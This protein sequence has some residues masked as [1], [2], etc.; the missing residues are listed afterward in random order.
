MAAILISVRIALEALRGSVLRTTLSTLG[1]VMGAASL[2]AVLSLTDGAE[3]LARQQIEQA[4]VQAIQVRPQ[5]VRTVD[6]LP[7]PTDDYPR[8]TPADGDRLAA[9]LGPDAGV[10][11]VFEGTTTV[12]VTGQRAR[13]AR[14]FGEFER[15]PVA[16]NTRAIARGRA[17]TADEMRTGA[18]VAV[19]GGKLADDFQRDALPGG[20]LGE[21]LSVVDQVVRVVGILQKAPREQAYVVVTPFAVA[22]R[23]V[24]SDQRPAPVLIVRAPDAER[25]LDT[26][27]AIDRFAA[28]QP[29]WA[30]K[31]IVSSFGMDRLAQLG[32]AMQVVRLVFASFTAIS[33]F[34]G[35]IGIMNVLLSS[36]LERTREIGVRKAAGARRR[37]ILLQFLVEASTISVLGAALGGVVGVSGAFAVTAVIRART[38]APLYAAVTVQT[39]AI[40]ALAAIVVG[41]A[42][43]VYPAVRASKL[44][45]IDAIQRE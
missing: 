14:L 15:S 37:D 35:G 24:A 6:G 12:D 19:I 32:Q 45:V 8:F 41:L 10:R 27:R 11:L 40:T 20:R 18:M 39:L 21:A 30:G 28:A 42:A 26:R 3:R 31:Y 1:V 34:V 38:Q 29:A 4:G 16:M 5:T 44:S 7:L 25:T 2:A 13:Y 9:A 22:A 43:G 33:L 23:A 36:I 17:L